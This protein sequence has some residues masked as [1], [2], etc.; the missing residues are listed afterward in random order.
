MNISSI[1]KGMG[2]FFEYTATRKWCVKGLEKGINEPAKYAAAMLVTS[3]VSKDLVGCFVYTTQSY[4]NKKIPENKRKFVAATDLMNGIIM[5]GG[6]YIIGGLIDGKLTPT[7]LGKTYSGSI[8]PTGKAAKRIKNTKAPLDSDNII[9]MTKE[10]LK[11]KNIDV[12]KIDFK[13][14]TKEVINKLGN[15]SAKGKALAAGFGIIVVAIATTA[16]TKRTLA[17]L[18]STPLATWFNNKYM[19]KDK[20]TDGKQDAKPETA[21]IDTYTPWSYAP[22]V[23]KNGLDKTAF[24]KFITK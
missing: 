19:D 14:V 21:P 7:L 4:N 22:A 20:K 2:K 17:P 6:Q 15:E 10:A 13:E 8:K 3:I 18:L 12:K 5:V 16:L 24:N 9:F 11:A 1:N 23:N